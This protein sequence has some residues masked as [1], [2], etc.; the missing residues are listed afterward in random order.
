MT[1]ELG[2]AVLSVYQAVESTGII[3]WE[4]ELQN[5]HHLNV[6]LCP[7]RILGSDG[8]ELPAGESGQ[9]VVSNL[10]NR[11]TILLN[12]ML[13][14][15]AALQPEWCGC[16]RSLPLLSQLEGRSTDWLR[17]ASGQLIHPQTMR[18]ILRE[19]EGIRRYQLVQERPGRV[20]VVTVAS[21]EA[22]RERIRS[23]VVAESR[24]LPDPIEAE[25]EFSETLPRTEGGK[26]LTLLS[27]TPY[28]G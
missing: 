8:R 10:V 15:L 7:I 13:G 12:Y 9:V 24:E 28:S 25:V 14:D 11:G 27:R 21:P 1:E 19:V 22:D 3:G 6:D 26:V 2:I 16:G 23:R 17:S 4:C 20:R 18:G 5:G